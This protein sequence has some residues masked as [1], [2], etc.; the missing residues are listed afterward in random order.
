MKGATETTTKEDIINS[1]I[2]PLDILG[3]KQKELTDS[4]SAKIKNGQSLTT[5]EYTNG[6]F[7]SL[8][9]NN[10]L[11][12]I[13]QKDDSKNLLITKKVLLQC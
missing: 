4:E 7:V 12:A 13:S 2:N 8:K 11:C 10:V 6:E 5:T 3:F 9:S 1:L